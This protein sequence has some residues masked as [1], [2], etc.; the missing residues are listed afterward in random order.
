ML[1]QARQNNINSSQMRSIQTGTANA[2]AIGNTRA[3]SVVRQQLIQ[4]SDN[5]LKG[6]GVQL[7]HQEAIINSTAIK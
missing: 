5:D 1:Q 4:S 3:S 6:V 7:S 2:T